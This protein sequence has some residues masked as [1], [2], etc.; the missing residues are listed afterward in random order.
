MN[1]GFIKTDYL[2]SISSNNEAFV[3]RMLHHF[4]KEL[5]EYQ[6]KMEHDYQKNDAASLKISAHKLKSIA[7]YLKEEEYRNLCVAIEQYALANDFSG[8]TKAAIEQS[9]EYCNDL[10]ERI[11]DEMGN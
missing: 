6:K 7:A 2:R 4:I 10:V 5:P 9:S 3:E 8:E 1:K 11:K